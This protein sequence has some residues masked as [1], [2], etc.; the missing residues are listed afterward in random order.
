M[1]T[2]QDPNHMKEKLESWL[3]KAS[4]KK[5]HRILLAVMLAAFSLMVG[6]YI[7]F[8]VGTPKQLQE[9]AQ[10]P[11][12]VGATY[13]VMSADCSNPEHIMLFLY[14]PNGGLV[15]AVPMPSEQKNNF[16]VNQAKKPM[17]L[18]VDADGNWEFTVKKDHLHLRQGKSEDSALQANPSVEEIR[19]NTPAKGSKENTATPNGKAVKLFI[20]D[21]EGNK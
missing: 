19:A 12:Q 20:Q 10:Q 9:E 3:E 1:F 14:N 21:A 5:I 8:G 15:V 7:V 2:K 11:L 18:T 17:T 16:P 6:Y 13:G 4:L